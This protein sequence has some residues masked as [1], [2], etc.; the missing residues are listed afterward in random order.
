MQ[1]VNLEDTA[2]LFESAA[3]QPAAL[4]QIQAE[5]WQ[6]QLQ[7]WQ[8][9]ALAGNSENVVEPERGD[10]RFANEEW[11]QDVFYNFIKQ[12]Y[13]LFSKNLFANHRQHRRAGREKAKSV[14]AFFLAKRLMHYHRVTLLRRTRSCLSLR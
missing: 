5:W 12:S 13:L 14:L 3:N 7:I 8:N 10:K 6:Q 11:Q 1:E 9:V 4:L 2:K